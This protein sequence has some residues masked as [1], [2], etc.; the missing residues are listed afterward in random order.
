MPQSQ[1]RSTGAS[2]RNARCADAGFLGRRP[3]GIE[4]IGESSSGAHFCQFSRTG[5]APLE[6]VHPCFKAG[7]ENESFVSLTSGTLGPDEAWDATMPDFEDYRSRR[8][9]ETLAHRGRFRTLFA[10][11]N[12]GAAIAEI[13]R[14]EAGRSCDVRCLQVNPAFERDAG[15]ISP[16]YCDEDTPL[17]G[18]CHSLDA[19]HRC[20]VLA[21]GDANA[22]PSI[23]HVPPVPPSSDSA[24]APL[25]STP[26]GAG[27]AR[28][29]KPH[30]GTR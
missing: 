3:T 25:L 13:I 5:E 30:A 7:L 6:T 18:S 27:R 11:M 9:I 8:R 26:E 15:A 17:A 20:S 21:A 23:E 28:D 22:L 4:A 10:T 19:A 2:A 14:D 16:R 29:G 12:Q 24:R 1:T